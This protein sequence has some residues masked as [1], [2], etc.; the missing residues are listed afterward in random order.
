MEDSNQKSISEQVREITASL[1]S[2]VSRRAFIAGAAASAAMSPSFLRAAFAW[3]RRTGCA[4]RGYSL[5]AERA[6]AH[7]RA[8]SRGL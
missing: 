2:R 7:I 5:I 8:D 1:P 3:G 4:A 6:C